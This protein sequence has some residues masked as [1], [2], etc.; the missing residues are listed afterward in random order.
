MSPFAIHG[1]QCIPDECQ[2]NGTCMENETCA[3][4]QSSGAIQCLKEDPCNASDACGVHSVCEFNPLYS[5]VTCHCDV[6]YDDRRDC[7]QK[8]SCNNETDICEGGGTCA[9]TE[10]DLFAPF[11]CICINGK[12]LQRCV[13]DCTQI[14]L[15]PLW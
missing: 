15:I 13:C 10:I 4:N 7:R 12:C 6:G 1:Y 9:K 3:R 2:Y 8:K 11:S 14:Q 5:N